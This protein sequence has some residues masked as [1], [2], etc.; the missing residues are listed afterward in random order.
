MK[1][2][3]TDEKKINKW[4]NKRVKIDKANDRDRHQHDTIS[5]MQSNELWC[6]FWRVLFFYYYFFL[7]F[8]FFFF[9]Y[10]WCCYMYKFLQEGTWKLNRVGRHGTVP[11]VATISVH[12]SRWIHSGAIRANTVE[13]TLLSVPFSDFGWLK[14]M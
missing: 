6:I 9:F 5:S 2:I 8:F 1:K 3:T 14:L 12:R 11:T 7:I 13:W 4:L 10:C